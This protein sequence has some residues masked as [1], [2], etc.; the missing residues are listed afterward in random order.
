MAAGADALPSFVGRVEALDALRREGEALRQG[1]GRLT[2]LFGDAGVGKSTLARALTEEL[3]GRG[4]VVY[5]HRAPATPDPPPLGLIR[6]AL[7]RAPAGATTA[8]AGPGS[9][10]FAPSQVPYLAGPPAESPLEPLGF[11]EAGRTGDD[12][13]LETLA[14]GEATAATRERLFSRY[15][16]QLIDR[17]SAGPVLLILEDLQY[18]DLTSLDFLEYLRPFLD[19]HR[20]WVLATATPPALQPEPIRGGLERLAR[21]S[22]TPPI[23]LR[24]LTMAEV[25][26]FVRALSPGVDLA[27]E[28]ITRWHSQTGGN[29]QF[30]QEL[31]RRRQQPAGAAATETAGLDLA[32]YLAREVEALPEPARHTLELMSVL[33]REFPFALLLRAS[34]EREEPLTELVDL[35]IH[36]G[37][38]R[39]DAD[40]RID[41]VREDL[42]ASLYH[43]LIE[44]RRRLLHRRAG[45]A[46]ETL[47]VAD[48]ATIFALARHFYL[49]KAD[50]R[51]ALF[52]RLAADLASRAFSPEVAREHLERAIECHRRAHPEDRAGL[53]D[54]DLELAGQLSRLGEL[55]AAERLLRELLGRIDAERGEP[56]PQ[57]PLAR[58]AL[59]RVLTDQGRW[60]EADRITATLL[61]E[62]ELPA[63]VAAAIHRMRGEVAYFRGDY[64]ASLEEHDRALALVEQGK[65]AREVARETVRRANVLA[66]IDG[67]L[68][69]ALAT[70]RT[71]SEELARQGDRGEAAY[72][73]LFLGVTLAQHGRLDAS[74][75]EL[76]EALVLAE[77]GHDQRR[78]G[79]AL[80]NAADVLRELGRLTEAL[81]RNRRARE[82]LERIGDRF[83]MLQ[84]LIVSGK[85]ALASDHLPEAELAFLEAF[86]TVREL[87]TPADEVEVLL[88]LAEVAR[89]RGDRAVVAER[90]AELGRWDVGRIRPDLLGT[91]RRLTEEV[92]DA[93]KESPPS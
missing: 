84:T 58:L 13:L 12:R 60:D 66:M 68:D 75:R 72:A 79:W 24:P 71:A 83:G 77:A 17:T 50:D 91:Y 11:A 51:S 81:D 28:E 22:G 35:L 89:R 73:R 54:L 78:I 45:E 40:E 5:A 34:G 26:E 64:P 1:A 7:A 14:G 19:R 87:R 29:P 18:A 20:L 15:A 47:G 16:E 88:R 65:D 21:V 48:E 57:A 38:I 10:A 23:E 3:T 74:L 55:A 67:R 86:R 44:P 8:R 42:R 52:N 30:L 31:L 93:A 9:L 59:A 25:D 37:L 70:Y 69:E 32:D 80:F 56:P 43:R 76:E 39:E 2:L 33:G 36:R 49:G 61:A 53:V 46:L 27:P 92:R 82:V 85:I 63:P 90:L 6:A 4:I 41:F 62:P